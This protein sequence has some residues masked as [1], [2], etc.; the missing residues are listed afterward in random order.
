MAPQIDVIIELAEVVDLIFRFNVAMLGGADENP[1]PGAV[2]VGDFD[3]GVADC[4]IGA[5][6]GDRTGAG[7]VPDVF[8]VLISSGIEIAQSGKHIP[9]IT[10]GHGADA[11][12]PVQQALPE[13]FQCVA[14][15]RGQADAGDNYSCSRY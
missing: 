7:A 12:P 8:L 14:V 15:R 10:V 9:D 5:E 2:A 11:G 3:A 4:L 6:N 1:D 13:F